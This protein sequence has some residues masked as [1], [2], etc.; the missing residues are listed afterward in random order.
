MRKIHTLSLRR[1]SREQKGDYS[2][3]A[4]KHCAVKRHLGAVYIS[5]WSHEGMRVSCSRNKTW[6]KVAFCGKLLCL[7]CSS[8][9]K[10]FSKLARSLSY[11]TLLRKCIERR[12]VWKGTICNES[13]FPFS[14]HVFD[15]RK[16]N[17]PALCS[18]NLL[19]PARL[20]KFL[21]VTLRI[22]CLP[23]AAFGHIFSCFSIACVLVRNSLP[24]FLFS[25]KERVVLKTGQ[26]WWLFTRLFLRPLKHLQQQFS[27]LRL[28]RGNVS[29]IMIF[30][31]KGNWPETVR[32]IINV[33]DTGWIKQRLNDVF[34]WPLL[35]SFGWLIQTAINLTLCQQNEAKQSLERKLRQR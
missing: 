35:S 4:T 19:K 9:Q 24:T 20:D 26:N 13:V 25:L 12:R 1:T 30:H 21:S 28:V 17:V 10:P 29:K 32:W 11:S 22:L 23:C 2:P 15:Q 6:H 14:V 31:L 16:E 18:R 8:F 3:E 34:V 27:V 33:L 7:S 5:R